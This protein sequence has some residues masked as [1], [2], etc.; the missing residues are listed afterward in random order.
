[1]G[2]PIASID[3]LV[4]LLD[5]DWASLVRHLQEYASL[6]VV[7]ALHVEAALAVA[8]QCLVDVARQIDSQA[9]LSL[10]GGW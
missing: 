3:E 6:G 5:A 10:N 8:G 9:A 7:G 1:M 2:T 4:R